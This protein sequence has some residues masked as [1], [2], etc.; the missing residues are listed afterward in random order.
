MDYKDINIGTYVD[1]MATIKE[2]EG[3]ELELHVK[4]ISLV[5]GLEEDQVLDLPLSKFEEYE[6]E[7]AFLYRKPKITGKIPN[8]I[9]LN[10]RKYE[11]V[12]NA[13]KLTASQYIDYQSYLKLEDPDSHIAQVLSVFLIP[14]GEKYGAYDIEPVVQEISNN[15]STQ[16]A[17]DVCFF[18]RKKYLRSI[19]NTILYLEAMM[20]M[21]RRK[22]KSNPLMM[23]KVKEIEKNLKI[24]REAALYLNEVGTISSTK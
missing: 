18:F 12:K 6:R 22:A 19:R 17:L 20:K 14:E 24:M 5:Y 3:E 10:G 15:L 2:H 8:K 13:K 11:V 23:E 4:L 16:M 1:I 21:M 9:V 7:L